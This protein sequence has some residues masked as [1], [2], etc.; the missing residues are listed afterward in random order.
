MARMSLKDQIRGLLEE[1]D[2]DQVAEVAAARR[3]TL[4]QL[5]S[6]TYDSDPMIVYRAIEATGICALRLASIDPDSVWEHLRRLLWMISEESGGI[7]W[8]APE[9]MAEIVHRLPDQFSEYLEV[10][11][12]FLLTMEEEDLG[13]FRPGVLRALGLLGEIP[14]DLRPEL[15]PAV[16]EAL[17]SPDAQTRGMAVWALSRMGEADRL[18]GRLELLS[19]AGEVDHYHDGE[20]HRTT[21]A[22]LARSALDLPRQVS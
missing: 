10:T 2:L 15:M 5:V 7:C 3:R 1:G 18:T 11:A 12:S 8:H 4:G 16:T 13:H 22:D 19:D 20:C 9:M 6:L 21:V 17:D 14:Q